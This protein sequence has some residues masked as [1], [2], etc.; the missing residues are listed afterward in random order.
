[1]NKQLHVV[2]FRCPSPPNYGGAIEVFYKIKVLA[3]LGFKV[4]LHYF[5]SKEKDIAALDFVEEINF[6][7]IKIMKTPFSNRPISVVIRSDEKLI[8]NLAKDDFP[9]LFEGFQSCYYINDKRIKNRLKIVRAHNIEHEYYGLLAKSTSNLLKK[10]Y[11]LLESKRYKTFEAE[12]INNTQYLLAISESDAVHFKSIYKKTDAAT[13]YIPPFHSNDEVSLKKGKGEGL[14]YC[15]NL[16]ISE[17]VAAITQLIK[18]L[19]PSLK[20]KL[21]IAGKNPTNSLRKLLR[22]HTEIEFIPNPTSEKIEALFEQA[23]VH[24]IPSLQPTG[25]KLKLINALYYGR[26]ILTTNNALSDQ[27]IAPFV[28]VEDDLSKWNTEIQ[29]ML[30]RELLEE[31]MIS[32]RDILNQYFSNLENGKKIQAILSKER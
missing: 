28:T 19:D 21:I 23:Q 30:T 29:K 7:P 10:R 25:F 6:Y 27:R 32:R 22:N 12:V 2:C 31:E 14:L 3:D 11:L 16:S 8:L 13:H 5:D 4:H 1:M 9:I 20:E 17:N 15:G 18:S 24:L 26:F